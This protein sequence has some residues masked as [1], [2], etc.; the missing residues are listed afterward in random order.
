MKSQLKIALA[1]VISF[2]WI[3]HS[4]CDETSDT[5]SLN[6]WRCRCSFQGNQSYSLANC[7]KSCDCHSDAEESASVWTCICDPNGFPRV[8]ADGHSPNCFNACNC[9]WGTVSMP[10][11]PKKHVSSKIVVVILLICVICTTIAFLVSVV[12]Y[13]YR[14]DRCTIQSPIFSAD[15]ETSSG[16]TTNLISHRSG[17]S[18][19]PET[20]F[21][22]NSSICHISGCFQ[23]ASF[24][25]GS[26]KE[27]Y[28]G[29]I[30]QFSLAELENAT[31]NF[32][33]SNLIGLGGSSYVYLGRL[34]DGS[35]V[36][37]KR[38][39]DQGWPEVDSA[40]F[41]EIELLSRLHH[42]HLV[43]LLGYCSEL[44]GKHVQRLLVFD[45]MANGNLR[46]CLDG[47]SGKHIDWATRVMIAIGAARGLEYLHEAAA[48]RILHRDVKST[49]ILLDENWQAKITDL[50]MAK[51]L[52][53][54]DLPS[55][56]N[57]PA[58]MQGTFGYFAP[59]YAIVGR[60]SLE[61]DVFSFGVVLL[62]LIS[63]RQPIHKS[64][65]KEES[66][67]IWA[68]PR[69]QDSRRVIS[70]LVDPQLKGNIPE[71]E[72]QVMAYL[73]KEC[74]LLD[75]DTRPT[76]SE[77]VQIL[78]SISPGKSRRRR[79][80]PTSLFQE[81]EAAE[82]QRQAT[83]GK[84]PSHSSLPLY[85]DHN[86]CAENKNKEADTVSAESMESLILL[87]AKSD[88]SCASEEEIV[89]L[90]EPRFEAFCITNGNN[91]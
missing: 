56:S 44:K 60:A 81:P 12:C 66:L 24:L 27:T 10:G 75:P 33:S 53:S 18:S 82:K 90:T 52:R 46:D 11:G 76:M 19:V 4:F 39:K 7:S 15:K 37:V 91:P 57:S 63:G 35:N 77:V 36:A 58:R 22:I 40:F 62:E 80:I 74:L 41:K 84:F 87:T 42:C 30:I 50:G 17:T 25:F 78:S 26:P 73:A 48:P 20:K 88:G 59:E 70:E 29:N 49:N 68:T 69:L 64:T 43:P 13:V 5:S 86:L 38:L 16:S 6:K 28:H 89:D 65:G 32:S 85:I 51:N 8:A 9:T 47:V 31:E 1:L 3:Q 34:K 83:H 55:C 71:E 79:N 23:K 72:V 21:A 67:V 2:L 45:Y 54:D 61:S 14:R